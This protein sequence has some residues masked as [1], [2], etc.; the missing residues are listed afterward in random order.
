LLE[1]VSWTW[2]GVATLRIAFSRRDVTAADADAI[3]VPVDG[4]HE[5]LPETYDA[6]DIDRT[7]I[8]GSRRY[9]V[10][11]YLAEHPAV[12]FRMV[13]RNPLVVSKAGDSPTP[14]RRRR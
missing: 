14:T 6:D 10:V 1:G 8:T 2:D 9:M 3:L 12:E 13:S 4:T 5:R 7:G 11:R